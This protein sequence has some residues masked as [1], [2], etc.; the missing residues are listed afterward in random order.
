MNP[1]PIV[2]ARHTVV[3]VDGSETSKLAVNWA[4][5]HVLQPDDKLHLIKASCLRSASFV[6]IVLMATIAMGFKDGGTCR[7][8]R[9]LLRN[10]GSPA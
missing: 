3:A 7:Q 1:L 2:Q 6:R 5:E 4:A 10:V 8:G 9:Q